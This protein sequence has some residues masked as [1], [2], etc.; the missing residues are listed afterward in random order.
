M[1]PDTGEYPEEPAGDYKID[2]KAKKISF[3]DNGMNRIEEILNKNKLIN[4]SLFIDENFEYIHYFTQALKAHKLFKKDTDYVVEDGLVQIV[5]EFTGR[6]LHGRRYSEGLHQAI[7]AKER[8]KVAK[9]NRTL[10]TITFQ[11]FFRMYDKISGMTGTADTEAKEFSSIY[12][13]EVVVIPTNRPLARKDENDVIFLNEKFKYEAICKEIQR[14]NKIGQPILVGTVSIEKSELLSTLLK[15]MGVR[16][17][18]LN[19][20]NHSREAMIIAGS[21]GQTLGDDSHEYGWPRNGYKAG[22]QP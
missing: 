5:D 18:V 17:E 16:H 3:T 9:R 8:I 2:E 14:V 19:A 7:E 4:G 10:A 21:R 12:N 11:N 22:R 15:Q 13:L 6:I 20:K 1:I